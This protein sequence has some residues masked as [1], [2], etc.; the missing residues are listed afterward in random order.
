MFDAE[1]FSLQAGIDDWVVD[2]MRRYN[3]A[4]E[5]PVIYN[6]YQCYLKSTPANISAH[7]V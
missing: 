3:K 1:Q 2:M 6:T 4:G 5:T 7:L